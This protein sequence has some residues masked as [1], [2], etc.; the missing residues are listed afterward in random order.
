[1]LR[2]L[3]LFISSL[4]ISSLFISSLFISHYSFALSKKHSKIQGEISYKKEGQLLFLEA[5]LSIPFKGR[6]KIKLSLENHEQKLKSRN[7]FYEKSS[8]R[9]V[10][11]TIF[12][13][14]KEKEDSCLVFQGSYDRGENAVLY[15]GDIF[16]FLC[17]E[18]EPGSLKDSKD[19]FSEHHDFQYLGGFY[20][21]KDLR[22]E[23]DIF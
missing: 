18:I 9:T 22:L 20:F 13:Y 3:R 4:F 15:Y 12:D 6:G 16:K 21:F 10:F 11:Y 5:T 19:L 1:M 23:D 2:F 8:G 14:Y 7:F 17:S